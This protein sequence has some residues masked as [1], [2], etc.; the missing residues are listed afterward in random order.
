[1]AELVM[2]LGDGDEEMAVFEVD[3]EQL[4]TDLGLAAGDGV[5]GRAQTT[6]Q[7]ALDGVRPALAQVAETIRELKPDETEIQF[8]LKMG[9][10]TGVIIAKGTAE[11]NFAVRMVWKS[12]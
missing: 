9:G 10:E 1:M 6:L 4:G 12:S 8:G 7:E 5:V 3:A 11:V 2:A